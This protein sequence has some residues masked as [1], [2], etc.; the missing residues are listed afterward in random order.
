[1]YIL[2]IAVFNTIKELSILTY[3]GDNG[4]NV[5]DLVEIN[6]NKRKTK[7][8]IIQIN[9][10][11]IRNKIRGQEF[12]IKKIN[13]VIQKHFVDELFINHLSYISSLYCVSISKVI[14]KLLPKLSLE[15][16]QNI[17][18][19]NLIN[20]KEEERSIESH[21]EKIKR[22]QKN[23]KDTKNVKSKTKNNDNIGINNILIF[24][25]TIIENIKLKENFEKYFK[26]NNLNI[27]IINYHSELSKSKREKIIETINNS[28]QNKIDAQDPNS[29][30]N[31][32]LIFT[33][34]FL[35]LSI[36]NISKI[37]WVDCDS[38]YYKNWYGIETQEILS[39][40]IENYYN[41]EQIFLSDINIDKSSQ[42][43]VKSSQD[44]IKSSQDV[45]NSGFAK[46]KIINNHK[47]DKN[48][49]SDF[50]FG[51]E[52]KNKIKEQIKKHKNIILYTTK[53]SDYPISVC[54]SCGESVKCNICKKAMSLYIKEIKN[55]NSNQTHQK[56]ERYY[57]C[58]SCNIKT[59]IKSYKEENQKDMN[60]VNY[61]DFNVCNNCNGIDIV[62]V[63]ISTKQILNKLKEPYWQKEFG[64]NND[65]FEEEIILL[66]NNKTSIN[67]KIQI[68]EDFKKDCYIDSKTNYDNNFNKD[69]FDKNNKIKS[70]FLI[71]NETGI[72]LLNNE[73]NIF[74]ISLDNLFYIKNYEKD[75]YI[76]N[77]IL[78]LQNKLS[79]KGQLW[80]QTR[81][82]KNIK[83][84]NTFETILDKIENKNLDDIYKEDLLQRKKR[85]LPP[86]SY[87]ISF[88][89]IQKFSILPQILESF[90]YYIINTKDKKN[91]FI[92]KYIFLISKEI[93]EKDS[94]LRSFINNNF[95]N[96][97]LKVNDD[98]I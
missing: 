1:M 89:L 63:G 31:T 71:T 87:I 2:Q 40:M 12:E 30:N 44:I 52:I 7:G 18:N 27:P 72:Q 85:N 57:L 92:Y 62:S 55:T 53:S 45:I 14:E 19:T 13:K 34:S 48:K 20:K 35:P 41:I 26:E 3:I 86:F 28:N 66:D 10:L 70:K 15:I 67:K 9:N 61:T 36:S 50:I 25:P 33:P 17:T 22:I 77:T 82:N 96:A 95:A 49:N 8:L 46:V 24:T 47:D 73:D 32:L 90:K 78:N 29:I 11:N 84:K 60:K 75:K 88:E 59:P 91:N 97:N 23:K 58:K 21:I 56:E 37:Y 16:L 38:K 68:Y 64:I 42:G 80:W 69:N 93:W 4:V 6:L 43:T 83:N 81:Q 98:N 94:D 5:G 76:L 51:E 79:T 54:N 39:Y 65:K 74:I